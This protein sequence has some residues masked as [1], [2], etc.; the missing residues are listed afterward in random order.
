M[1]LFRK[2]LSSGFTL[3]ELLVVLGILSVLAAVLLVLIDPIEQ[4]ARTDDTGRKSSIAQLSQ[5]MQSY[6]AQHGAVW[7]TVANWNSDLVNS[8]ELK[9]FP[10]N[11]PGVTLAAADCTLASVG[12][13]NVNDFCYRQGTDAS[14][15]VQVVVYTKMESKNERNKANNCAS[16]SNV[17][18]MW[19]SA[20][21]KQGLYCST[22]P[23]D[24][25]TSLT[26]Y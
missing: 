5:A 22:T 25:S 23:P 17:Y 7:P 12:G 24:T 15:N 16:S 26:L 10:T 2:H 20:M 14:N 1:R 4:F 6:Y 3:I 9:T 21:G 19:S 18:Y 13:N 8:G 11:P